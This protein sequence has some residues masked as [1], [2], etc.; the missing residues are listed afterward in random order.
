MD[1]GYSRRSAGD[2]IFSNA[3]LATVRS[4]PQLAIFDFV[5]RWI[6]SLRKKLS[7]LF[8]AALPPLL[9]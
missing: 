4:L 5:V 6:F 7:E 3:N 8:E 9:A 2:L 1:G